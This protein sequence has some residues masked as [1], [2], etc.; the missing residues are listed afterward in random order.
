MDKKAELE[1]RFGKGPEHEEVCDL[2]AEFAFQLDRRLPDGDRKTRMLNQLDFASK[3]AH[4]ALRKAYPEITEIDRNE[5]KFLM[6][7][8]PIKDQG[9]AVKTDELFKLRDLGA[10]VTIKKEELYD[11]EIPETK[12][13]EEP[14][15]AKYLPSEADLK[16]D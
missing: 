16:K 10:G 9:T 8:F 14:D 15:Y 7:K 11:T 13:I 5:K 4:E 12:V 6:G 2:F 1:L 3:Y